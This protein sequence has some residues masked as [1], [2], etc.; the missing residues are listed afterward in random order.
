MKELREI[1]GQ[2]I[3][4]ATSV[5]I[6]SVDEE[7]YPNSKAMLP[8]RKRVGIKT[9]YFL[10]RTSSMRV[11]HFT[12]NPK[13]SLYFF[14]ED[15]KTGIMFKGFVEVLYDQDIID[16]LWCEGDDEVYL[17][18]GAFPDCSVLKFSALCCRYFNGK[19]TVITTIGL[20][21]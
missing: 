2:M 16:E 6:G 12:K 17:Y 10:T 3:E 13:A 11:Q 18:K 4:D 1:A 19:K 20:E 7:G 14:D 15:S 9:M 8:P 21:D 5:V